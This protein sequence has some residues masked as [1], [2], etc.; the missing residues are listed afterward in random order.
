[1][2]DGIDLRDYSPLDYR[3]H[4]GIVTQETQLFNM[5][6]E[7]NIAY[8]CEAYTKGLLDKGK[9]VKCMF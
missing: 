4:V 7:D 6:I 3:K 8:G 9:V 1:M 5:T 2:V